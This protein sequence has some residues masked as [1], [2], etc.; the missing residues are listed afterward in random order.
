M[1]ERSTQVVGEYRCGLHRGQ[2]RFFVLW[3]RAKTPKGVIVTLASSA[4]DTLGQAGFD[5]HVDT[6]Y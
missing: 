3:N 4:T 6:H 1:M 5:G 2:K